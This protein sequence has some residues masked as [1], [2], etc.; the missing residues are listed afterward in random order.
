M[1]I[2]EGAHDVIEVTARVPWCDGECR[3]L[4][5]TQVDSHAHQYRGHLLQ[6]RR[7][8]RRW[9]RILHR[10]C[11]FVGHALLS[12][13]RSL[14]AGFRR[15]SIAADV[16]EVCQVLLDPLHGLAFQ[17]PA[18]LQSHGK[19][20][21]LFLCSRELLGAD[22]QALLDGLA[23]LRRVAR[24]LLGESRVAANTGE[25]IEPELPWARG[26]S[27]LL[28]HRLGAL[29]ETHPDA[30]LSNVA[31]NIRAGHVQLRLQSRTRLC[32]SDLTAL[33]LCPQFHELPF[34][35]GAR[36]LKF[37]RK[38]VTVGLQPGDGGLAVLF[39]RLVG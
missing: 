3:H 25:L 17:K 14:K 9:C 18:C 24:G 32:R 4:P 30:K 22:C 33:Q 12:W 39:E 13:R 26:P 23:T 11:A 38:G 16:L 34:R 6:F 28:G 8:R 10:P 35:L 27:T 29:L 15:S 2:Q 20:A 31:F 37:V 1:L 19:I 36:S 21:V 7:R 5:H